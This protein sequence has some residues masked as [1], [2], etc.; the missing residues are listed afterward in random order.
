MALAD[1]IDVE[2]K[3]PKDLDPALSLEWSNF[4]LS[5]KTCNSLKGVRPNPP[6]LDQHIWPDRD[7]T[8]RGFACGKDGIPQIANL[9]DP[10]LEKL[11]HDTHALFQLD[12]EKQPDGRSDLRMKHRLQVH[13]KAEFCR[14]TL[15]NSDTPYVRDLIVVTATSAGFFS[16]WMAI[17]DD[18]DMRLRF[19][20]RQGSC[21]LS[22]AAFCRVC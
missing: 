3:I 13:A 8:F 21:R 20:A 19:G 7:N 15:E 5:C 17:F 1:A 16:I 22:H 2:H 11:A 14:K 12:R 10:A 6:N 9:G 18:A 4:L